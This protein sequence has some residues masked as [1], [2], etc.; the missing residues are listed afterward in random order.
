LEEVGVI[1]S[2]VDGVTVWCGLLFW[3]SMVNWWFLEGGGLWISLSC[4]C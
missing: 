1:V 4:F 2:I 3:F